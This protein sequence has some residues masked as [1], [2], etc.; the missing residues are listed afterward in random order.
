[1]IAAVLLRWKWRLVMQDAPG[2]ERMVR[3]KRAWL[4]ISSRP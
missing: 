2:R 1:L 4:G 3:L